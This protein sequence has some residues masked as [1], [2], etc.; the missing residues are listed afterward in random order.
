MISESR[1]KVALAVWGDK[2][3]PVFDSASTA[4]V[5][6]IKDGKENGRR[7]ETLGPELPY[8][9]ALKLSGWGIRVLI[10]G[11]IST[12]F[13]R[14]IEGYGVQVISFISGDV[15]KVVEA[16][17]NGT[18]TVGAFHMPGF[19]KGRRNRFRGGGKRNI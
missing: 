19:R 18:L 4:L 10:C 3:S 7:H 9:R 6:E 2:M 14:T 8:A 11:A 12:G 5:V 1:F 15:Q 16:Y 17:L 13:T